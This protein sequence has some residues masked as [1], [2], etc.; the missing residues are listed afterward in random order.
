M[1]GKGPGDVKRELVANDS[2]ANLLIF[3]FKTCGFAHFHH[4]V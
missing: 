3:K 4:A 1:I 2:I